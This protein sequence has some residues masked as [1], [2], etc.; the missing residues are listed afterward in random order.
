MSEALSDTCGVVKTTI[1]SVNEADPAAFD[2]V[3]E[4]MYVPAFAYACVGFST[5][6]FEPSPKSQA[7]AEGLLEDASINA[8]VAPVQVEFAEVLNEA[9]GATGGAFKL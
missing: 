9:T 1:V 4:I 6:A 7:Q 5:N 2:A 8:T 3:R